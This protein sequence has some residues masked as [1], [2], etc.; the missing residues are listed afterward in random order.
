MDEGGAGFLG[1]GPVGAVWGKFWLVMRLSMSSSK[2]W[3]NPS[4]WDKR[5]LGLNR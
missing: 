5:E 3:A 2:L 4:I 1:I